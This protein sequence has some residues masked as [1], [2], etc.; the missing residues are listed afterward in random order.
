MQFLEN[1]EQR[2]GRYGVSNVTLYLVAA[3]VLGF[4]LAS[5]K[6]ESLSMFYLLGQNVFEGEVWRLITFLAIPVD[7]N[8]IFFVFAVYLYY[9]Y[10]TALEGFWGTFRYNLF[11]VIAFAAT[12]L[13]AA[14][15]PTLAL[16]SYHVYLL[17]FLAFAYL[18]PD[19][20][21]YLIVIPVKIKWLAIFAWIGVL[22]G[23]LTGSV[24]TQITSGIVLLNFGLFFGEQLVTDFRYLLKRKPSVRETKKRVSGY[25]E[26][27]VSCGVTDSDDEE[28]DFRYCDECDPVACY[29]ESHVDEHKHR[30]AN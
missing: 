18:N 6:P 21:L 11:L 13:A 4:F 9:Q 7:R 5:A 24:G 3:Q 29:C 28:M 10:G 30:L 22:V 14:V 16:P 1:L 27:C 17:I 25:V 8:P 26:K 15:F 23:F 19:F 20:T 12:L 2:F